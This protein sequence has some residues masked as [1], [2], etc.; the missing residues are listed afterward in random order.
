MCNTVQVFRHTIHQGGD[1][2]AKKKRC[3]MHG[4]TLF[5]A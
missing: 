1:G 3:N 5:F 2:N 4:G